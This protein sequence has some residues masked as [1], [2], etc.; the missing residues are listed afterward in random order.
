MKRGSVRGGLFSALAHLAFSTEVFLYALSF[1]LPLRG[2]REGM[3]AIKLASIG[4]DVMDL[5][6]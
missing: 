3:T 2:G 4:V 1:G 6:L 5:F